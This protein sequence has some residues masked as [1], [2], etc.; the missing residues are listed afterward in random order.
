MPKLLTTFVLPEFFR[1][2]QSAESD[3]ISGGKSALH[4]QTDHC[5]SGHMKKTRVID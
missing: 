3:P 2:G 4:R 1:A 5:Y